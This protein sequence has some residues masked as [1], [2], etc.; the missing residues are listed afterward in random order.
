MHV[1]TKAPGGGEVTLLYFSCHLALR[2]CVFIYVLRWFLHSQALFACL[3]LADCTGTF[4]IKLA[5]ST[6]RGKKKFGLQLILSFLYNF[7]FV[8]SF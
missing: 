3:V 8:F 2:H 7:F 1:S 5:L 6:Y 4:D